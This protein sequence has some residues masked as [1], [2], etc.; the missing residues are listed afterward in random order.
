[1][2]LVPNFYTKLFA[3]DT[4]L[5]LTNS[6]PR[7]LNKNVNSELFKI[8]E[9][10][11]LNKLSLNTNKAKFMVLTKQRSVWH[12]DIRTEKTNVKQVNEIKY[13][14]VI[15]NDKLSWKFQMQHV[16]SALSSGS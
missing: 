16:C 1:M 13:L 14:G 6:C 9:C 4:V 11:K 2:S 10:L 5:T 7:L 15:F 3:D 8:D 12:F